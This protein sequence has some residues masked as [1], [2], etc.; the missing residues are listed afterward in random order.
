MGYKALKDYAVKTELLSGILQL[1]EWDQETLMP[2]NAI[3]MRSQQ[4]EQLASLIHQRRTSKEFINSLSSLIDLESGKVLASGLSEKERAALREW[5]RDSLQ[6]LKLPLSFIEEFAKATT[7]AAH[8][9]AEKKGQNDFK[10]FEPYLKKIV[11]LCRKKADYLG[12]KDHPYD[13]LIDSFEPTMTT[14]ILTTL[15]ERLKIPLTTLLKTIQTKPDPDR[16]FLK[17]NYPHDKQFALGKQILSKMGFDR[18]F[19]RL[20]ESAHPMC[21]PLAPEDIRMT[22]RIYTHDVLVNILSCVHE[23]GH[24]LYHKNLPKQEYGTPLGQ[25]A[26]LAIDESQ[27]R[28]WET[29]IGRSLSFW[30]YIFPLLQEVFPEQ[31]GGVS[32]E[33]LYKAVNTVEPSLIRTE[34]DEVS[35]NLHILVRFEIEKEL[36]AGTLKVGELPDLW[37]AKMRTY[38]GIVPKGH[39]EGCMQDI[40]WSLGAIGYF[41]TYT[42]GNLYAAQFFET[43]GKEHPKWKDNVAKGD[44]QLISNWQKENIHQHGRHYLPEELCRRVTGKLLSQEPFISYLENK[45]GEIYHL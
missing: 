24:A 14:S 43:F 42:L 40:H 18:T 11:S 19:S 2:K 36:I 45:Y 9:W 6:T 20:D 41:P 7:E 37:N 10:G 31:L 35:Y 38:L 4:I 27:S 29:I 8:A 22:T 5:R 25:A 17:K 12:Y 39:S 16:S 13:P 26:S 44:F 34:S 3:E 1:L 15:F 23:G 32:L 21:I 30:K 33:D 28:S